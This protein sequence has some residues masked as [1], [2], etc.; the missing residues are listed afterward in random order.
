MARGYETEVAPPVEDRLAED[1]R[2]FGPLGILAILVI[3]AERSRLLFGSSVLA[4]NVR[5]G[6]LGFYLRGRIRCHR[7]S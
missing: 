5:R 1:L 6:L 7:C 4:N 2:G 3:L